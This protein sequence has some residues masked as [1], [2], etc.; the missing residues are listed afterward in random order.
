MKLLAAALC[1]ALMAIL[2]PRLISPLRD[3]APPGGKPFVMTRTGGIG[4]D[5]LM[6]AVDQYGSYMVS[7]RD[8]PPAVG[9]MDHQ[10][11]HEL[12]DALESAHLDT[13]GS[14][15]SRHCAD[16]FHYTLSYGDAYYATDDCPIRPEIVSKLTSGPLSQLIELS[17]RPTTPKLEE[18]P[19][20]PPNPLSTT[21]SEAKAA[22]STSV[23]VNPP[24]LVATTGRRSGPRSPTSL[25]PPKEQSPSRSDP[26]PEPLTCTT[27]TRTGHCRS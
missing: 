13:Q 16:Q 6:I 4:G 26:A 2:I 5:S 9:T 1:G 10:A 3:K 15:Y 11:H 24:P 12:T 8:Q 17:E 18:I 25:A 14:V 20:P 7:R 19:A 21:G 22:S 27:G 23:S